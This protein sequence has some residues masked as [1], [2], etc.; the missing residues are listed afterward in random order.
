MS[1]P[2]SEKSMG[3]LKCFVP[4]VHQQDNVF[5]SYMISLDSDIVQNR[6]W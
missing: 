5:F 6:P 4:Y 1:G 2:S 3:S